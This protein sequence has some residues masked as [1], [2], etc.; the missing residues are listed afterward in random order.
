VHMVW[1]QVTFQYL[2]LFPAAKFSE[3]LPQVLP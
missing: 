3:N 2:A 1:H